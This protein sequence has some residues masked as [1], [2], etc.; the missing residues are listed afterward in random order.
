MSDSL[1]IVEGLENVDPAEW[2]AIA[3]GNPTVS[4]AFLDSLHRTGCAS[5]RS[6]WK[7]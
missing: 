7:S 2:N 3:D 5:E 4:Y 1:E 6:G